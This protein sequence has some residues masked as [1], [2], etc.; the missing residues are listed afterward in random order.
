M[1]CVSVNSVKFSDTEPNRIESMGTP[2]RVYSHFDTIEL[3]RR[4]FSFLIVVVLDANMEHEDH[5][6][7]AKIL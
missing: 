6:N 4:N 5:P 2:S 1:N 3:G 7:V